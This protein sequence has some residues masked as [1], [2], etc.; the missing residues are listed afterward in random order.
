MRNIH[1]YF[2]KVVHSKDSFRLWSGRWTD[3]G[4]LAFLQ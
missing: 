4:K 1:L 3:G 2:R